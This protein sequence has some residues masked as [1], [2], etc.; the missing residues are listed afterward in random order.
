MAIQSCEYHIVPRPRKW[1]L[2]KQVQNCES[3][4]VKGSVSWLKT[5]SSFSISYAIRP[6]LHNTLFTHTT[7]PLMHTN[8]EIHQKVL[9]TTYNTN[10]SPTMVCMK[11]NKR[12]TADVLHCTIWHNWMDP[13]SPIFYWYIWGL[14][15]AFSLKEFCVNSWLKAISLIFSSKGVCHET[16]DLDFFPWCEPIWALDKQGKVF[17]NSVSISLRYSNF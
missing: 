4:F 2:R 3:S 8:Y 11:T 5:E 10:P 16:F 15:S 6:C 14:G 13:F 9:L 17:S 7:Q 12:C 1:G